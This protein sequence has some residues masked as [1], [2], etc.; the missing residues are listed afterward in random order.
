MSILLTPLLSVVL[1]YYIKKEQC[2]QGNTLLV[3]TSSN[4]TISQ[5]FQFSGN[6]KRGHSDKVISALQQEGCGNDSLSVWSLHVLSERSTFIPS[7][8]DMHE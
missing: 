7:S 5:W 4:P 1:M 8:K 2:R 6:R 3:H